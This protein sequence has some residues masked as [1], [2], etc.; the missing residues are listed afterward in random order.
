MCF[1]L[2]FVSLGFLGGGGWGWVVFVV[3]VL[4]LFFSVFSM[5]SFDIS[6]CLDA[7]RYVGS[8][9]FEHSCC[10]FV[11]V[12]FCCFLF[13]FLWGFFVVGCGVLFC[14]GVILLLYFCVFCG[15]GFYFYTVAYFDR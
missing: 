15:I 6:H 7:T 4:L 13:V 14:F 5:S 9:R 1:V 2:F 12:L 10:V 11:V 8:Q 3:V